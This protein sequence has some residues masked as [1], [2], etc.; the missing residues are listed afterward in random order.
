M[1][2]VLSALHRSGR[3]NAHGARPAWKAV[4]TNVWSSILPLSSAWKVKPHG[5]A[6]GPNPSGAHAWCS[7]H[8]PSALGE[9][10]RLWSLAR[11]LSG[12]AHASGSTP[13]FSAAKPVHAVDGFLSREPDAHPGLLSL[14]RRDR[15]LGGTLECFASIPPFNARLPSV[16]R[17]GTGCCG[18]GA[19][20]AKWSAHDRRACYIR[21]DGPEWLGY[22][23][24]SS[25]AAT[26]CPSPPRSGDLAGFDSQ[27][28]GQAGRSYRVTSQTGERG[29][30]SRRA[31]R[32]P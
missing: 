21:Y 17:V 29:F 19:L 27:P 10:T 7:I 23:W 15:H 8:P 24:K 26:I 2:I 30:N 28:G 20:L 22:P 16:P 9:R 6:V 11:L 13:A 1:G 5:A 32:R 25:P 4:R 18:T 3:V 12:G 31:R 14:G